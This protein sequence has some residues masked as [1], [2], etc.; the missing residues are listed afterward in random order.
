MSWDPFFLGFRGFRAVWIIYCQYILPYNLVLVLIVTV[1][2]ILALSRDAS[3]LTATDH[4]LFP[5]LE[6][7]RVDVRTARRF[8]SVNEER[9]RLF[10]A[11]RSDGARYKN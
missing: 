1:F 9:G 11:T 8:S 5:N 7:R 4:R 10:A 6:S 3:A 2:D